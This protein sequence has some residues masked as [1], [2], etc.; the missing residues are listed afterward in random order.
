MTSED[1]VSTIR[2]ISIFSFLIPSLLLLLTVK[3]QSKSA[4]TNLLLV[5]FLV[6]GSM[7]LFG[8]VKLSREQS[9]ILSNSFTIIEFLLL[10]GVYFKMFLEEH[11]VL[12]Y[13]AVAVFVFSEIAVSIFLQPFDSFQNLSIVLEAIIFILFAFSWKLH[14]FVT[15]PVLKIGRYSYFWINTAVLVYFSINLLLFILASYVFTNMSAD[16]GRIFWAF[17][18]FNN[19]VK[20]VLFAVGL[21]YFS[22]KFMVGNRFDPNPA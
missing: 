12:F 3:Q 18:N 2:I 15:T 13:V 14:V 16:L 5:L 17:H 7:D 10:C 11:K 19:I 9:A 22:P 1:F 4:V 8:L 20:N 6:S 21:Y